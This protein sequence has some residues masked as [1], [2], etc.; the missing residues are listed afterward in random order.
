M[1]ALTISIDLGLGL[2]SLLYILRY[3]VWYCIEGKYLP[4]CPEQ[5]AEHLRVKIEKIKAGLEKARKRGW[6][7]K[8]SS[9]KSI[10]K[11][12]K[13]RREKTTSDEWYSRLGLDEK[14]SIS[15]SLLW[16]QKQSSWYVTQVHANR[17]D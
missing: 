13:T 6:K 14:K 4:L 16:R 17:H 1:T 2:N 7:P 8:G 11:G 10:Q 12:W 15:V 9:T 3:V 5:K